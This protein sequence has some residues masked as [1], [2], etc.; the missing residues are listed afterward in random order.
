MSVDSNGHSSH[1]C[2]NRHRRQKNWNPH[3]NHMLCILCRQS[4]KNSSA[5]V[6]RSFP[7]FRPHH[8]CAVTHQFSVRSHSHNKARKTDNRTTT[9]SQFLPSTPS[10][11][12]HLLKYPLAR[13]LLGLDKK[14][15]LLKSAY[16]QYSHSSK[17]PK[18]PAADVYG[19]K[20]NNNPT[21]TNMHRFSITH[22]PYSA[23]PAAVTR[24]QCPLFQHEREKTHGS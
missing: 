20:R 2:E 15:H 6:I 4:R 21:H 18:C 9:A 10:T 8:T 24:R 7:T 12:K 22:F 1:L 17:W 11:P 3:F 19:N 14:T 13:I 16:E 23:P 5:E